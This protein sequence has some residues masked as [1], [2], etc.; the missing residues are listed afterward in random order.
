MTLLVKM[1]GEFEPERIKG[2]FKDTVMEF[3]LNASQ[4]RSFM[5]CSDA[6]DEPIALRMDNIISIKTD[7]NDA[8]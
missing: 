5:V 8:V 6:D 7:P 1:R 3:Q 4:G 2:E